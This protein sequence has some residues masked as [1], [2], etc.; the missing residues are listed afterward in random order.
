VQAIRKNDIAFGLLKQDS[1]FLG[2]GKRGKE[3]VESELECRQSVGFTDQQVYDEGGLKGVLGWGLSGCPGRPF[4]AVS[5][6]GML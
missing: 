6:R 1:L 2:L 5:P 3:A 4:P